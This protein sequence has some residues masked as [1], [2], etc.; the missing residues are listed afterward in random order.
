MKPCS[1]HAAMMQSCDECDSGD[2]AAD[3]M[4]AERDAA[5]AE[6]EKLRQVLARI[7][8]RI[9]P[10]ISIEGEPCEVCGFRDIYCECGTRA[11]EHECPKATCS[12]CKWSGTYHF[13]AL[14]PRE[15]RGR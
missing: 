13:A 4:R 9:K 10:G 1:S 2:V 5:R 11:D 12:F 6:C 15:D 3:A 14:A 7:H 8:P